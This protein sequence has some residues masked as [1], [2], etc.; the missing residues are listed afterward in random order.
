MQRGSLIGTD[1]ETIAR[2][3]SISVG[4]FGGVAASAVSPAFQ[5]WVAQTNRLR[6][7]VATS[8]TGCAGRYE[9]SLRDGVTVRQHRVPGVGRS[10]QMR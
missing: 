8:A 2:V 6:R 7:R 5:G 1:V 3:I 10:G 4:I 9:P